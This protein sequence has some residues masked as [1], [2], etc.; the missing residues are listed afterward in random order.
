[1]SSRT[2]GASITF[3]ASNRPPRPASITATSTPRSAN[4][5]SAAGRQ[6]LELRERLGGARVDG[7]RRLLDALDARREL[8]RRERRAVDLDALLPAENVR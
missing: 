4:A 7:G 3:V 8:V 2:T 1:M 5:T 6:H